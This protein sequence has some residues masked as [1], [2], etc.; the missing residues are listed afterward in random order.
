MKFLWTTIEV[1]DL[2]ESVRFY[3]QIVGLHV[4]WR[5]EGTPTSIAFMGDGETKVELI[6]H[7]GATPQSV[8]EGISIGFGVD[9]LDKK[10]ADL[11][12]MGIAIHS[13]PFKPNPT[14][15]FCYVLDPN[16]VRIQFAEQRH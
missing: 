6:C 16:G 4:A 9:D 11:E 8:G 5:V 2:E 7:E 3:E 12:A 1:A 10:M 13:G 14:I 15:R